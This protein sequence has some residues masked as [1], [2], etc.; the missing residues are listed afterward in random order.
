M[1][2]ATLSLSS[3]P[4][5]RETLQDAL[6][7]AASTFG[8][9][10]KPTSEFA[11]LERFNLPENQEVLWA[12]LQHNSTHFK[13]NYAALSCVFSLA[14]LLVDSRTAVAC[15]LTA[16]CAL[17]AAI[18]TPNRNYQLAAGGAAAV[19]LVV[20]TRF[21]ALTL[22]G[23]CVGL[24]LCGAHAILLEQEFFATAT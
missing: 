24:V 19:V 10:C 16:V 21:L 5:P 3:M 2:H 14:F 20:C 6:F 12:R 17:Y 9:S 4:R 1:Q 15:A 11:P 23:A 7:V 13:P 18:Q 22:A 8:A